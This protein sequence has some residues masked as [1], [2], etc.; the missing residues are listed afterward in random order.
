MNF[1]T[2]TALIAALRSGEISATEALEQSI[3][4]IEARDGELNAVVVRDFE[5]ARSA[6]A[7]AEAA[8]SRGERRALLGVPMTVKESF[9]VA[10]LPTTWGIPGAQTHSQSDAAAVSRLRASGAVVI[11]KTNI[12]TGLADL[13]CAN[14]VYGVTRNPW[15]LN[16]TPG[17]SSGGAAAAL[18]AGFVGLELG[19]DLGGSLRFPAHCCGVFSHKPTHGIVPLRGHAPPGTPELSVA[20]HTDLAVAGPMA[21][22]AADLTLA[23][24]VLAGPDAAQAAGYSLALPPPRRSRLSEF[25]ILMLEEHPL[26]PLSIEIRIAMRQFADDLRRIG[27][28]VEQSSPLLPDLIVLS[29][30]FTRLL[31]APIGAGLPQ[32]AYAGLQQ[33]VAQLPAGDSSR[34]FLRA[35]ALVASHRDWLTADRVRASLTHQWNQLFRTWDL[36]L[37]P[38]LPTTAFAH[39]SAEMDQRR[40]DIDGRAV[41]FGAQVAW[42]ALASVSGLPATVMPIGVGSSGLPIGIQIVGAYLEDRSTMAFAD[43]AEREFGGFV[44]PPGYP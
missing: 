38:V 11:G 27:C 25:K 30:T 28:V 9:N 22:C 4:R 2:T 29:D 6:S 34:E 24:D 8:L 17:G 33:R 5:R 10:G 19:S 15:N 39:D 18:A 23:M 1:P 21:R 40:V 20:V 44:P 31:M 16:R 14:P 42:A 3:A 12:P 7:A 13:Q 37:C 43:L 35:R 36:V 41:P 32:A 26:L